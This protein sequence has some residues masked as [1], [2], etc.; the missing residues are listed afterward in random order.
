MRVL[1]TVCKGIWGPPMLILLLLSGAWYTVRLRGLQLTRMPRA[2]TALFG[3]GGGGE[4]DLSPFE[5]TCVALAATIGTGNIVGVAAAISTGGAGSIFWMWIS[6]LLCLPL[7]FVEGYLGSISRRRTAGGMLSGAFLYIERAGR[8]FGRALAALY[9]FF[10]LMSALLGM[11]TMVQSRSIADAAVA[12]MGKSD[13]PAQLYLCA[14][15]GIVIVLVTFAAISRGVSGISA[16]TSVLVP[17]MLISYCACGISAIAA[18]AGRLPAVFADILRSALSP[19]AA[20]GGIGGAALI[21]AMRAGISKGV[22]T[23][24]AGLGTAAFAAGASSSSPADAGL[25]QMGVAV[26]DT[27]IVCSITALAILCTGTGAPGA[28]PV[29]VASAAFSR[30]VPFGGAVVQLSLLLFAFTSALGVYFY[31][32]Q[33]LGYLTGGYGLGLYNTLF[34]LFLFLGTVLPLGAI[35]YIA[36]IFNGLMAYI[37]VPVLFL[38][39]SAAV[40]GCRAAGGCRSAGGLCG[41][42]GDAARHNVNYS[43]ARRAALRQ[44]KRAGI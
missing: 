17:V 23:N 18:E 32:R 30:A 28:D 24:E 38:L 20:A 27:L 33:S 39:G 44:G 26:V 31:G 2:L 3:G 12:L 10:C 37:N 14:A 6:T 35:W 25:A 36:D 1:E 43:K 7:R 9:A 40:A 42:T 21:S 8:R 15:C 4:G 13:S 19:R 34:L 41:D 29:T 5:S 22:F 11:G 16:V